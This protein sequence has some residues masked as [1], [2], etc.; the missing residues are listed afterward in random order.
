MNMTMMSTRVGTV[1]LTGSATR[2]ELRLRV[3]LDAPLPLDPS[4]TYQ[5]WVKGLPGRVYDRATRSWT[6]TGLGTERPSE[7]L[8]K[9]G[10]WIDYPQNGPL[11]GYSLEDLTAPMARHAPDG[12]GLHVRPRLLGKDLAGDLLGWGAVWNKDE[13]WF[14]LPHTDATVRGTLRAGVVWPSDTL[15]KSLAARA[16]LPVTGFET[17]AA[18]LGKSVSFEEFGGRE[19]LAGW[20]SHIPEWFGLDLFEYQQL[21]AISTALGHDLLADDQGIGKTRSAL[22]SAAIRGV[23]RTI[24]TCPPLVATNWRK[25]A[26]ESGLQNLGGATEGTIHLIN[27]KSKAKK[28]NI[29]PDEGI[30]VVPDSTIAARPELLEKLIAWAPD[31]VIYDEA[32]RAMTMGTHRSNAI[33]RLTGAAT[34]SLLLTGTPMFASPHQLVPLLEA[35]GKLGP[36]FGSRDEFLKTYCT[37]DVVY[38]RFRPRKSALDHLGRVLREHVFVRRLKADVLPWLPKKIRQA[39]TVDVP[40]GEYKRVHGEIAAKIEAWVDQVRMENGGCEPSADDIERFSHD[41]LPLVSK[42]RVAAGL[43]KVPAAIDWI[44]MHDLAPDEDGGYARPLIV[45]AHHKEVVSALAAAIPEDQGRTAV[46]NAST[47]ND[48]RDEIVSSFQA[49]RIAVLV[50]SITAAGVGITLTRGQDAL[51]AESDWT[52]GKIAQSEDRLHRIGQTNN[53]LI[54]TLIA[55]GTLDEH[56]QRSL[57]A[58]GLTLGAVLG[59]DN[60]VAVLSNDDDELKSA[61]DIVRDMVEE[62]VARRKGPRV[63]PGQDS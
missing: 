28:Q 45:W 9:L 23:R 41:S 61:T 52:V 35:T 25:E 58:K 43:C 63:R 51:Y 16:P 54:T 10:L 57:V 24:V 21:G 6:I 26:S 37:R 22:A 14:E 39:L 29:F 60:E 40:L 1:E 59:G 5:G 15:E 13:E 30:I 11:V 8:A 31:M 48:Q 47:T 38:G 36:V 56:I 20:L 4:R 34:H 27:P 18:Q 49:G 42:L 32:H 19:P 12:F 55:P 17:F 46:L 7:E 3:P 53:V 62:V 33:L 44:R 50:A 2:P